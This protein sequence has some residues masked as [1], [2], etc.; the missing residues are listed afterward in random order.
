MFRYHQS[1]MIQTNL[2]TAGMK[3][4]QVKMFHYTA[5]IKNKHLWNELQK[6]TLLFTPFYF[7]SLFS[8]H[9]HKNNNMEISKWENKTT[10]SNNA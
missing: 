3:H 7:F 4:E 10:L 2:H 6:E 9:N 5:V 1:K 8:T